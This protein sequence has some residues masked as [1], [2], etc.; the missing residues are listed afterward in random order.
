MIPSLF[1][2]AAVP[3]PVPTK[4]AQSLA[5]LQAL[6]MPRAQLNDRSAL[7]LL[8]LLN[9]HPEGSWQELTRPLLGV[10]PIMDWCRTVYQRDYKANSRESFRKETLHQFREAGIVLYNPDKPDRP[11]NS[12][13][14][15]YQVPTALFEVVLTYGTTAWAAT[16][17]A[18]LA[19]RKT[20]TAQYAMARE[21]E[22]IPLQVAPGQE[23]KL[24]AGRHSQLISD[25]I[26][27]FGPRFAP[28][29]EVIYIGDT[30]AKHG[31]FQRERLAELG[32]TVDKHGKMPDVVLYDVT[33]NWL[34]LI[35]SVTS[36]GP[37]DGKRYGE[38]SQLFA[39]STA[40]LVY[41][42]A[43]PDRRKMHEY[44]DKIAWET[45]VW[46]AE[47]PTHLIHFNGDRYLGPHSTTP[48]AG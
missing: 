15:C 42:T 21:M 24:S 47:A 14:A 23:I 26:T 20:L 34:L 19:E 33:R 27:D 1:D 10:T 39:T 25:I 17:S 35:E 30:G 32:V 5:V 12:P 6:G 7:T 28:G 29:A 4:I 13:A 18:Y 9:L 38:L 37:V 8:A 41:V 46:V 31:Y 36:S 48:T 43:F 3:A 16:L 11:V 22:L 44:W 2:D 45:E 40:G